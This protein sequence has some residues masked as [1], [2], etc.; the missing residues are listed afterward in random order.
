MI[1]TSTRTTAGHHR[2]PGRAVF[3]ATVVSLGFFAA[4]CGS[5]STTAKS[6]VT[7]VAK[8]PTTTV[9][10]APVTT[11]AKVP[12]TTIAKAPTTT[13]VKAP[14]TTVAKA[15]VTTVNASTASAMTSAQVCTDFGAS[16]TA[17][18]AP[19]KGSTDA[20]VLTKALTAANTS[21]TKAIEG[22]KAAKTDAAM[23]SANAKL[24]TDLTGLQGEIKTAE[25]SPALAAGFFKQ[26]P[27]AVKTTVDDI[28][29]QL[30]DLKLTGCDIT[31][32]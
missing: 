7:T 10:K 23:Q 3:A 24:V 29:K 1:T 16:F 31:F 17:A 30:T 12:V 27:T 9:A 15:P 11:V 32:A 19:A 22:L 26:E 13:V 2:S 8:A 28:N 4:A 25:G 18:L 14:V 5:S 21:I 6:P 20:T